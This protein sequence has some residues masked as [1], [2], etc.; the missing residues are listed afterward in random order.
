MMD[1]KTIMKLVADG[2]LTAEQAEESL[3]KLEFAEFLKAAGKLKALR[4]RM[5]ETPSANIIWEENLSIAMVKLGIKM[6]NKVWQDAVKKYPDLK[7]FNIDFTEMRARLGR[8]GP[9]S[10]AN[11]VSEDGTKQLKIWLE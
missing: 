6:S 7:D 10:V 5:E 2:K 9:E 8:D 4:I 11:L 3:T 1:Q